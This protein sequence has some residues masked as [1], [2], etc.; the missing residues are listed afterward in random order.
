MSYL[1]R[2]IRIKMD[3]KKIDFIT[4]YFGC[5]TPINGEMVLTSLANA[6]TVPAEEFWNVFT[7]DA[8]RIF[9]I[10]ESEF[11]NKIHLTLDERI[12]KNIERDLGLK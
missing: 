6:S 8:E 11:K 5:K 12:I 4:K 1:C 2:K 3:K 9:D 10:R 7:G